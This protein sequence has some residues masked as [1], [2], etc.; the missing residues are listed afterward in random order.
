MTIF[1]RIRLPSGAQ[2]YLPSQIHD[3]YNK[4]KNQLGTPLHS[5]VMINNVDYFL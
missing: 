2:N 3:K 5:K 4:Q 1:K